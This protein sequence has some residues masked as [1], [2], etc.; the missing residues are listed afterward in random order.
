MSAL[1]TILRYWLWVMVALIVLQIAF[2]GY[3]A[4][5]TAEKVSNGSID[6]KAFEDSLGF[7]PGSAIWSCW[8]A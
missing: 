5:D 7:T 8:E 3:G 1:R 4:F 6:E 2:A